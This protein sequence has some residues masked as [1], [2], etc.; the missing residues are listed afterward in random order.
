MAT[1]TFDTL[2]LSQ[3]L[4]EAGFEPDKA[5]KTAEALASSLKEVN[6]D[7]FA[8]KRD[9]L[10]TKNDLVKWVVATA[11]AQTAITIGLLKFFN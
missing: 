6:F 2:R 8:T 4:R 11:S 7:E 5:E 9:L 3:K 1:I 10:E